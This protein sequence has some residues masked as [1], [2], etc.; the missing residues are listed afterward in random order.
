MEIRLPAST[1]AFCMSSQVNVSLVGSMP[2]AST[3]DFL[4]QSSCAFDLMGRPKSSS[5]HMPVSIGAG[6]M[7]AVIRAVSSAV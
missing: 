4:Y 6:S 5:F 7:P 3:I 2:A 1:A